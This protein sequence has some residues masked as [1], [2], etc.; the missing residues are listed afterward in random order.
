VRCK[1]KQNRQQQMSRHG[2]KVDHQSPFLNMTLLSILG[3]CYR[4]FNA[5]GGQNILNSTAF[6]GNYFLVW[7]GWLVFTPF[8]FLVISWWWTNI[9]GFPG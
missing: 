4:Y 1:T 2:V 8:K 6:D 7:F 5:I 3:N 9:T